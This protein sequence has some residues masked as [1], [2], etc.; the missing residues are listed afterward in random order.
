MKYCS[1]AVLSIL[2]LPWFGTGCSNS[3]EIHFSSAKLKG[4]VQ[5]THPTAIQF[6]PDG[7]LYVAEQGGTLKILTID[8]KGKNRYRITK[9]EDVYLVRD[10]PNHDDDGS[11][12]T[13]RS[14]QVTGILVKGTKKN[15]V[16][17]VT[18]SDSRRT[19]KDGSNL[20][21]NSGVLSKLT[22]GGSEWKKLDLVRGLPRSKI[23]HSLNGMQLDD[24]TNLLY[25]AIGGFTNAGSPSNKFG[26]V[27]ETAL[28][29]A[30]LVIDLKAIEAMPVKDLQTPHAY[31]Y[32]VPTLD[33][34]TRS[35]NP[36][37]SDI[38]D[39]FGGNNGLNQAKLIRNGPVR[40]FASGFRNP[41]DLVLTKT[42][43][44]TR[45]LYA[46][47]NGANPGWGGYPDN[48]GSSGSVTNRYVVGE[49]GSSGS[50]TSPLPVNNL[51]SLHF[52]GN[53][54]HYREGSYY[55][56]HP[57]PIRANPRGA[58][59]YIPDAASAK[60]VWRTS[61]T[62]RLNPLPADW[63]P[64][65]VDMAHPV[66]GDYQDP[67]KSNKSF[68]TFEGST[69]GIAEYTA[70]SFHGAMKGNLLAVSLLSGFIQRIQLNKDG[71]AVLNKTGRSRLNADRPLASGFGAEPIDIV[72]Q[73]DDDIFPGTIWVSL[74]ADNAIVVF[75]P[76]AITCNPGYNSL[77]EDGDGY[78]NKD[79]KDNGS[80]PCLDGSKPDDFDKDHLSDLNDPDDDGDQLPDTSDPLALDPQNARSHKIPVRYDF[81][82]NDPG[83]GFFG[84]GFTGLMAN[85]KTNYRH[86]YDRDNL[87][88]GAAGGIFT[89]GK[90]GPG[91]ALNR[92]ND[93][94]NAFQFGLNV[95]GKSEQFTIKTKILGPFFYGVVK[96]GASQGIYLGTGD[97][98]NY[99]EMALSLK[100]G[101]PVVEIVLENNGIAV[102]KTY[103]L[104]KLPFASINLTMSID[105]T[106]GKVTPGYEIDNGSI[107]RLPEMSLERDVLATVRGGK[108]LAI[109]T[110]ATVSKPEEA[111]AASW[112]FIH[113]TRDLKK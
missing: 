60:G 19:D 1:A 33:D 86:L 65:P 14:R 44:K 34:P 11:T 76:S 104:T 69:N 36:D 49:P 35:N 22:W 90:V 102:S 89:I 50:G 15:P 72:A 26:Y 75:E 71:S 52:I 95:H 59:M 55:G 85:G 12:S 61:K 109:G 94:K 87:I 28:S 46:I 27:G 78:S 43:G 37:G 98:D 30:I 39:P 101:R 54:D 24:R 18:S 96:G 103:P 42:V 3:E 74:Y 83:T 38:G 73:G 7:R 58:G 105:P 92:R 108:P 56:G 13:V 41:Y 62:D 25:V 31:V 67:G 106:P 45:R 40:V 97:Q 21:T 47:D 4:N 84:L 68:L 80:D 51:D 57:N 2:L 70:S 32:D 82:E 8:R 5:L 66:E 77:D 93:Q 17:Y 6:G 110:I 112:D 64:V 23:N 53:L 113:V 111:Y 9:S 99:L 63:P 29:A 10:I 100:S 81:V 88:T 91:T 16:V 79:E 107:V 20:C 48:E